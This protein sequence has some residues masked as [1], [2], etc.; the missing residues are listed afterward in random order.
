MSLARDS[1]EKS[2]RAQVLVKWG[3]QLIFSCEG[4]I[5][6]LSKT[7]LNVVPEQAASELIQKP[8]DKRL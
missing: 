4:S 6:Y 3:C 2:T 7:R 8:V 1:P 5:T